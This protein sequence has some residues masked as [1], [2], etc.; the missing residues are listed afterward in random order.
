MSRWLL[1][2]AVVSAVA[3]ADAAPAAGPA[4]KATPASAELT[5][6]EVIA[7]LRVLAKKKRD[8][9]AASFPALMEKD[10]PDIPAPEPCKRPAEA[11]QKAIANVVSAWIAA[12]P[13]MQRSV[14]VMNT[15]FGCVEPAGVVVD[16]QADVLNPQDRS[17]HWWIL[18]IKDQAVE[19]LAHER[20]AAVNDFM[21]W[22]QET[23]LV[24]VGLADVDG[25]GTRDVVAA[26]I[27]HEGGAY[28]SETGLRTIL[29]R[30]H[31]TVTFPDLAD[32]VGMP[33]AQYHRPGAPLVIE[34]HEVHR[35]DEPDQSFY[36]CIGTGTVLGRCDAIRTVTHAV[37]GWSVATTWADEHTTVIPDRDQFAEQL[38]ALD[39]SAGE[40]AAL[41]ANAWE[42][43]RIELLMRRIGRVVHPDDDRTSF[44]RSAAATAEAEAWSAKLR[45]VLGVK[46]CSLASAAKSAAIQQRLRAWGD[47]HTPTG[48]TTC[49]ADLGCQ[50]ATRFE[51][52]GG[53]TGPRGSYY[54]LGWLPTSGSY[55]V[56]RHTLVFVAG[57]AIT[58]VRD[59]A[60]V[61]DDSPP[62]A[63][64]EFV[65]PG[66]M[67]A[68][69]RRGGS[70]DAIVLDKGANVVIDGVIAGTLPD[71]M[72]PGD[73]MLYFIGAGVVS[74]ALV[75][76][77]NADRSE[78]WRVGP[79][80]FERMGGITWALAT[81]KAD[82]TLPRMLVDREL[83]SRA[84]MWLRGIDWS[85]KEA[86]TQ[87]TD[88]KLRAEI[89][90]ALT[91]L[92]ADRQ[93]IAAIKA[94]P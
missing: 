67:V 73:T 47:T 12:Q 49:A 66:F 80:G 16:A 85:M 18:R 31:K 8:A 78:Y 38:A 27:H 25:D 71:D 69:S 61:G 19:V 3:S 41:L 90:A 9:L 92:K 13:G 94:L 81:V 68:F 5:P 72:V 58:S 2:I 6:A 35:G 82:N 87:L 42:P 24:T 23:M 70:V 83:A 22:T 7:R 45:D 26:V 1:A 74:E 56:H 77:R 86:E 28:H 20:G 50:P 75:S 76:T 29:S 53:C 57:D 30:S 4:S 21:E 79:S 33:H 51:I 10:S 65:D 54:E 40:R 55:G 84:R 63:S 36:R 46:S 37:M 59:F 44:E 32:T 91:I 64:G 15:R 43:D 52:T 17:G 34:I 11:Q 93:L 60:A 88:P 62:P 89:I 14:Q 48:N 39:V